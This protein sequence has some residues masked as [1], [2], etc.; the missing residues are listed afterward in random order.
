M[1]QMVCFP[2]PLEGQQFLFRDAGKGSTEEGSSEQPYGKVGSYTLEPS[3]KAPWNTAEFPGRVSLHLSLL[4]LEHGRE[5]HRDCASWRQDPFL[6]SSA[7]GE[8]VF[9]VGRLLGPVSASVFLDILPHL[10]LFLPLGL[11]VPLTVF[12]FCS[13][14]VFSSCPLPL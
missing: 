7:D 10:P 12:Y 4:L 5:M 6:G 9:V 1:E 11:G 13:H 14:D 8:E 3:P 2:S